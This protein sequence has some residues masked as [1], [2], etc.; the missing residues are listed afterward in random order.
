MLDYPIIDLHTHLRDDIEKHTKIARDSGISAVVYMA[1]SDPPLDNIK[2]IKKSLTAKRHCTALPVS[3]MTKDLAG[4][5]IVDVD[6][7]KNL[8]VGFSDD[9][10]YLSN[11]K[12]L[13]KI[14]AKD[15]LVMAHCC[16]S[17]QISKK[18]P[19]LETKYIENY[20]KVLKKVGGRL[21]IQH[22]S[23]ASSVKLIRKARASG[24]SFTCETVP[25]Y[26]TY[27]KSDLD[28]KVNPPLGETADIA[29]IKKG[30]AD[31]TIDVIASDYAPLPRIT[32]IAGFSSL[33]PLSYGLVLSKVLTEEQLKEKLSINPLKILGPSALK[34]VSRTTTLANEC[35]LRKGRE[36]I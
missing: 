2:T 31:G 24:L 8:A 6:A 17:Y 28:V 32:G 3:A 26:F 25:H 12:I 21:H 7:I 23:Q 20:L 14:L 11:L 10:N 22:V 9:G 33:I 5:E 34:F 1:N 35:S 15:V 19:R 30:L 16:P 4:K 27:T 13:A 36:E 29:E 18:N